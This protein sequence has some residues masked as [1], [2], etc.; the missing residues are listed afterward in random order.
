MPE[1]GWILLIGILLVIAYGL[2][3]MSPRTVVTGSVPTPLIVL[4]PGHGGR[5]PGAV[6]PGLTE[7]R[8]TLAV[9]EDLGPFLRQQGFRVFYT[10]TGDVHLGP[11]VPADLNERVRLANTLAAALFV[12]IHV[13]TEP[14]GQVWGPIVYYVPE[15]A[16]S[17]RLASAITDTL[18]GI[19]PYHAPRPINQ[20][21]LRY[22]HMP[23]VN[24][25]IGFLSNPSD[26]YRLA[27]PAF[28]IALAR[29][30]A[31]GITRYWHTAP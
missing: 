11:T 22:T 16:E 5:D 14:S 2:M 6:A 13:N 19:G 20:W 24:V 8:I 21:V 12:S 17:R 3:A 9:A 26:R 28:Q 25:E 18:R 23:A 15:S 10:R 7:K 1:R 30:V 31:Q 4:D 29:A 27:Q